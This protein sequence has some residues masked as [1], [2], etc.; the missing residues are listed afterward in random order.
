MSLP[1][2]ITTTKK[3]NEK[4]P[5]ILQRN[6]SQLL[7]HATSKLGLRR[8]LT[9]SRAQQQQQH[10]QPR[11]SSS[12][13]LFTTHTNLTNSSSSRRN[14]KDIPQ[15]SNFTSDSVTNQILSSYTSTTTSPPP[16]TFT[17]N[18]KISALYQDNNNRLLSAIPENKQQGTF[19]M[20]YSSS[21]SSSSSGF[22][23]AFLSNIAYEMKRQIITS[24]RI[25]N[26]IEY[27]N[28]FDGKEAIVNKV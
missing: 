28:V 2:T 17:N 19:K 11:P 12:S 6:S 16:L 1:Q 9:T 7:Q 3:L 10:V 4:K 5:S 23:R 25:K 20:S 14:V 15:P 18:S 21:S 24:D 27:N 13:V 26:G 22:Y 8:S